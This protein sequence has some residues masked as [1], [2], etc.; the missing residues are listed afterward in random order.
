MFALLI[1]LVISFFSTPVLAALPTGRIPGTTL[2]YEEIALAA[3]HGCSAA[4]DCMAVANWSPDWLAVEVPE[5][6][7]SSTAT[8]RVFGS[9]AVFTGIYLDTPPVPTGR[10]V[11]I[12][13]NGIPTELP[14]V[15]GNF[16]SALQP[17]RVA[18]SAP[19]GYMA[20]DPTV[21]TITLVGQP[22]SYHGDD[23]TS[24]LMFDANKGVVV[25]APS[26]A[27]GT[28]RGTYSKQWD[29]YDSNGTPLRTWRPFQ[30]ATLGPRVCRNQQ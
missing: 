17:C 6:P 10:Y 25:K 22:I 1:A 24:I 21:H 8:N 20:V 18:G 12:P 16:M 28:M 7:T 19:K 13:V 30:D 26:M 3:P 29:L 2:P 15:V 14:E 11:T 4:N 23:S 5:W 27:Y 9:G